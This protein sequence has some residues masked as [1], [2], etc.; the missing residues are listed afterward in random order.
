MDQARLVAH[1]FGV[2]VLVGQRDHP[3]AGFTHPDDQAALRGVDVVDDPSVSVVHVEC[4]GPALEKNVVAGGELPSGQLEPF[5]AEPT[6]VVHERASGGV[7]VT[8][9]G[10]PAIIIVSAPPSVARHHSRTS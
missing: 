2:E 6:S 4:L 5:T 3:V 10:A 7:E 9:L 8:H 1:P